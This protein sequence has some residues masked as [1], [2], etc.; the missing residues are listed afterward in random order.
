MMPDKAIDTVE[1]EQM[2]QEIDSRTNLAYTLIAL[3]LAALGAGISV[4]DKVP[5]VLMGAA[6]VSSYLW[7]FWMDHAGQVYKIA[8]YIALRLAPRARKTAPGALGWEAYLREIDAGGERSQRALFGPEKVMRRR[9]LARSGSADWSTGLLFG[10][11]PPLLLVAYGV[12]EAHRGPN[13]IRLVALA[14]IAL[15][16]LFTCGRFRAFRRNIQ[17]ISAAISA[18]TKKEFPLPSALDAG[19]RPNTSAETGAPLSTIGESPDAA[20]PA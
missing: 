1:Y 14:L 20:T 3:E 7:L 16:W 17:L 18:E 13:A 5:E 11:T 6:I 4:I 19:N 10:G 15:L 12:L 9:Q 8:S 2:R